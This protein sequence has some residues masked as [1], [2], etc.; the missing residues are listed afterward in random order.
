[1]SFI[2]KINGPIHKPPL[3]TEQSALNLIARIFLFSFLLVTNFN[4]TSL[5]V[6]RCVEICKI[7]LFWKK[8][9]YTHFLWAKKI[10]F[11]YDSLSL[12]L[13]CINVID[14]IFSVREK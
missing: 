13:P 4:R 2:S 14:S 8:V 5:T 6:I 1:M 9:E 3:H 7:V 10:V 12:H 11:T